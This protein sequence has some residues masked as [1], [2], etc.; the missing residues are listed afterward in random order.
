[1]GNVL[2]VNS[3]RIKKLTFQG[4]AI[5]LSQQF[6][7]VSNNYRA[8][9]GGHFP[10]ISD[11]KIVIDA[12]NENRQTV[13]DYLT[14]MTEKNPATGFDPS[15]DGNWSFTPLANTRVLFNGSS[16]EAAQTFAEQNP[17]LIYSHVDDDGYGVY[18][19]D[20]GL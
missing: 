10:G 15:A 14:F 1:A 5:N 17:A 19:V 4:Q 16:K 6:L 12:P 9:G 11:E 18:H 7:V 13:A 2:N 8:A 20:L 3:S